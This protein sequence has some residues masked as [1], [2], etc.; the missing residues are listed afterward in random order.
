[1]EP[2]QKMVKIGQKMVPY[3]RFLL[4]PLKPRKIQ[5]TFN[6]KIEKI[7]GFNR[8]APLNH[9]EIKPPFADILYP[10]GVKGGATHVSM[11]KGAS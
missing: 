3:S 7:R 11:I 2:F 1:M 10:P 5:P 9:P 8:L 4:M 6:P